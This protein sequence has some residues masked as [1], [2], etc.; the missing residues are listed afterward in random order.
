MELNI[1]VRFFILMKN[2]R[3]IADKVLSEKN[4][5]FSGKIVTKISPVKNY[6]TAENYHQKYLEKDFNYVN[7]FNSLDRKK[8]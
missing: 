7:S 6:C 5:K 8:S 3:N 1:G 4:I 2:K